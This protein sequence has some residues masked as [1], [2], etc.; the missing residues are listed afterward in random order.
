MSYTEGLERDWRNQPVGVSTAEFGTSLAVS[1]VRTLGGLSRDGSLIE[2]V[3]GADPLWLK[4][5]WGM[6]TAA[7]ALDVFAAPSSM[8]KEDVVSQKAGAGCRDD[9]LGYWGDND[10][11]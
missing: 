6:V 3:G 8:S 4:L 5:R 1:V 11:T 9:V 2:D 7:G 10:G